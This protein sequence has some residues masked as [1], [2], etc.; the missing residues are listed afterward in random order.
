M[1]CYQVR[2][3][4]VEFK[5]GNRAIFDA[6]VKALGW[7]F[8]NVAADSDNVVAFEGG[9]IKID[10]AS[11]KATVKE[12]PGQTT[13]QDKLNALKRSYSRQAINAASKRMG[14]QVGTAVGVQD[15]GRLMR[16]V[17]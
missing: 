11:G 8:S 2:T 7:R 17:G 3:Y 10:L 12:L 1:P 15:K 16:R 9:M 4:S 14:W 6:A 5:A 13:Y